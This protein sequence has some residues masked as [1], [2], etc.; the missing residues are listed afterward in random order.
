MA[1]PDAKDAGAMLTIGELSEAV[2]KPPH[3]LRYWETK[4]SQLKPLTRSGNRRY[5]RPDDVALVRRIDDL[6][7][8]RGFTI[9]GAQKE[10]RAP[11]P[12]LTDIR[13]G[14]PEKRAAVPVPPVA[15]GGPSRATVDALRAI[16]R[17]LVAALETV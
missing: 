4:F 16:R 11:S 8:R 2:G 5:Y 3:I 12:D 17:D 9:K 15:T 10:L 14:A 7:S 1:P 13:S 6:L